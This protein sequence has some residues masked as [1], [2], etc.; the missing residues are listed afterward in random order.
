M[1]QFFILVVIGLTSLAAYLVGAKWFGLSWHVLRSAVGRMFECI[2]IMLIFC[3]VNLAVVVI[4]ILTIRSLTDRFL[5][6][7]IAS[8]LTLPALSL[9]Q[10]LILQWWRELSAPRSRDV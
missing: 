7:E 10:A 2:G 1:E 5:P 6:L 8:D 4:T 9:L 3:V